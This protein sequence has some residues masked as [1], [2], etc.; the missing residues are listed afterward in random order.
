[1]MAGGGGKS[2][3]ACMI[4]LISIL[5]A[6]ASGQTSVKPQAKQ[7]HRVVKVKS[8]C[9]VGRT[10]LSTISVLSDFPVVVEVFCKNGVVARPITTDGV[11]YIQKA[12]FENNTST[13]CVFEEMKESPVYRVR[14]RVSW[15]TRVK[16]IYLKGTGKY[17]TVTC[18]YGDKAHNTSQAIEIDSSSQIYD[19]I[20]HNKGSAMRSDVS[21]TLVGPLGRPVRDTILLGTRLR[22]QATVKGD[23][24]V[25]PVSCWAT[26]GNN[27]FHVLLGGCGDGD[28]FKKHVGFH[29]NGTMI[30]SPLFRAFRLPGSKVM[31]FKCIFTACDNQVAC[32]GSSC[33]EEKTLSDESLVDNY[34]RPTL[35]ILLTEFTTRPNRT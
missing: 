6:L 29:I 5:L 8:E 17:Y 10:G 9:S 27:T 14:V 35:P 23:V 22:I 2:G 34:T 16:G 13:P 15:K 33:Y 31:S 12:T 30:R 19:E 7:P 1:M 24:Y 18:S 20:I 28:I 21:M 32:D 11:T 26:N 25:R 3:V 4:V